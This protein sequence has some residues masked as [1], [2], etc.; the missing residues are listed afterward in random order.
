MG[1]TR[2]GRRQLKFVLMLAAL[3]SASV[4]LALPAPVIKDLAFGESDEKIKAIG[5]LVDSGDS[6]ALP[7]LQSLL[8][9]EVQTVGRGSR[10]D[11]Q[12]RHRRRRDHGPGGLAAA[13]DA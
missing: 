2:A 8:D 3:W 13:R 10:P 5:A 12:G 11:R 4:A 7:L 1:K 6:A 9:G